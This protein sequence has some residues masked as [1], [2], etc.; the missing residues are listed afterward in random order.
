L[1]YLALIVLYI[2]WQSISAATKEQISKDILYHEEIHQSK[3]SIT[4]LTSMKR[5]QMAFELI[6][7]RINIFGGFD[8]E[9]ER[10]HDLFT[11]Q[12]TVT[13]YGENENVILSYKTPRNAYKERYGNN[14]ARITIV[15]FDNLK[16]K[17]A[18]VIG[19]ESYFINP[20]EDFKDSKRIIPS[21]ITH[22]I[23][24]ESDTVENPDL[25]NSGLSPIKLSNTFSKRDYINEEDPDFIPTLQA[26]VSNYPPRSPCPIIE[27][28][29][30]ECCS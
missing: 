1:T 21:G 20:V 6:K 16:I 28:S 29:C 19:N 27:S 23:Y 7:L 26:L 9:L 13:V 15:D 22:Y 5:D 17:G 25:L 12:S 30:Y 2:L 4:D 11:E 18:W 10:Y 3:I 24:R 8:I 14:L